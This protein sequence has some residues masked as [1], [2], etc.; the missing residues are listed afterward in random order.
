[1]RARRSLR[2]RRFGR[3]SRAVSASRPARAVQASGRAAAGSRRAGRG[4]AAG[5][6]LVREGRPV[7]WSPSASPGRTPAVPGGLQQPAAVEQGHD[8]RDLTR[9]RPAHGV[10]RPAGARGDLREPTAQPGQL[11]CPAAR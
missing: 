7:R 9:V 8:A 2:V 3:S 10:P 11:Q 5:R 1:M 6:S 4:R